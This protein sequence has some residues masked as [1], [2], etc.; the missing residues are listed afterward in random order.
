MKNYEE[1]VYVLI[2]K[3]L[4]G[5]KQG[6]EHMYNTLPCVYKKGVIGTHIPIY[7]SI[8]KEMLEVYI[9]TVVTSGAGDERMGNKDGRGNFHNIYIYMIILW[10]LE[11]CE[12][13]IY[14]KNK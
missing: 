10:G 7:L 13:I 8:H 1:T 5:E 2:W 12:C 6:A 14:S 9:R 11:P 4:Q 3:C